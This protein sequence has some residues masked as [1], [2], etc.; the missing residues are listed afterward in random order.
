MINL[1]K[2]LGYPSKAVIICLGNFSEQET[3]NLRDVEFVAIDWL[4][5][6]FIK[7]VTVNIAVLPWSELHA[8]NLQTNILLLH[9]HYNNK[10]ISLHI[11]QCRLY[12][13][14]MHTHCVRLQVS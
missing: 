5:D 6:K 4:I 2:F 3:S 8:C 10:E 12:K 14:K 7:A 11:Q 1:K 9:M 13:N